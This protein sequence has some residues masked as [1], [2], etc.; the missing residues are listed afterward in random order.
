MKTT[1]VAACA[2]ITASAALSAQPLLVETFDDIS[3]W[4][5]SGPLRAA[6]VLDFGQSAAPSSL[7][8]GYRWSGTAEVEDML[9]SLAGA[10]NGGPQPLAGSDA[11]LSASV[12]FFE[13]LGYYVT[14]LEYAADGLGEGWNAGPRVIADAYLVNGTYPSLYSLAG[15]GGWTG[16]DLVYSENDGM[17]S[18][19]LTDGGWFGFVQSNGASTLA[20]AQPV[21]APVPEPAVWVLGIL[22]IVIGRFLRRCAAAH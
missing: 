17:S 4:T 14:R 19:P 7:A 11:R 3:F 16:A 5:G 22:A 2:F 12:G 15:N 21:A 9:F 18:L 20:F 8:W 13:G 1:L 6:L 10:I